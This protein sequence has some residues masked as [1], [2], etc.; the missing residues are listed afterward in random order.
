MMSDWWRKAKERNQKVKN[1]GV[2]S[3]GGAV[4]F[5]L[6]GLRFSQDDLDSIRN[7]TKEKPNEH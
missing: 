4:H 3:E 2:I 6:E 1:R 5:N 7:F